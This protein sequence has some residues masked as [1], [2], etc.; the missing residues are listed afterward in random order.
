MLML[1]L[2]LANYGSGQA[3]IDRGPSLPHHLFVPKASISEGQE[4]RDELSRCIQLLERRIG[5]SI[6][7]RSRFAVRAT[8]AGERF[9]RE[10]AVGADQLHQNVYALSRTKRGEL[11]ELRIGLPHARECRKSTKVFATKAFK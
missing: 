3:S 2:H 1:K 9:L 4:L 5:I 6:L 11:G 7:E 8:S 10:A